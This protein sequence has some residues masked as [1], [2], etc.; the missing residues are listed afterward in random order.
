MRN[1][2]PKK[3]LLFNLSD[4]IPTDEKANAGIILS[5]SEIA[6][7]AEIVFFS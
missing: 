4:S 3:C 6:Y 1:T 7:L 5:E 2:S